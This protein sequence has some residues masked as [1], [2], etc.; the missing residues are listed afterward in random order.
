[1]VYKVIMV[2]NGKTLVS[3]HRKKSAAEEYKKKLL[4]WRRMGK[5]PKG[6]KVRLRKL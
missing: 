4:R 6:L 2:N 3:D 5:L 1:M